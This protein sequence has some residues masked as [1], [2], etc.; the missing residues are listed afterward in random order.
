[1]FRQAANFMSVLLVKRCLISVAS[2]QDI[3]HP[4]RCTAHDGG[5]GFYGYI[6]AAFDDQLIMDVTADEAVG[7]IL[8]SKAE[9]IPADSLYDVLHEL[10]TVGFDA[11]PLLCRSDSHVGDGFAAELVLT[12]ARLYVREYSVG[13][14]FDEEHSAL[15]IKVD[16]A[17][18]RM[19]SLPDCGFDSPV[20]IPP[21]CCDHRIRCTPGIN[22]RLQL[23]F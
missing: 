8:H 11:F 7:Q 13:R 4:V 19:C 1:M 10:R 17:Y 23:I 9:K 22:Q 12:D 21:V 5:Y 14:K 3:R 2:D 6:L 20:D 15:V 18:F 16:A